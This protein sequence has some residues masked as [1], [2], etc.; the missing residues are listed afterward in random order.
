M[1]VHFNSIKKDGNEYVYEY[2]T[3]KK[4]GLF[5]SKSVCICFKSR[6][7]H[8]VLE[9]ILW[10]LKCTDQNFKLGEII[11]DA[12]DQWGTIV[13]I[14]IGTLQAS[15]I[16]KANFTSDVLDQALDDQELLETKWSE[17]TGERYPNLGMPKR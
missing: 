6:Y 14:E 2:H 4:T 7:P 10:M 11:S 5:K 13:D 16:E 15:K 1:K 9:D 3:K 12:S 17:A 8:Y